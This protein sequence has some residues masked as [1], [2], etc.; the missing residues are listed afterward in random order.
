MLEQNDE[1]VAGRRVESLSS[2]SRHVWLRVAA[3]PVVHAGENDGRSD[4]GRV[5]AKNPEAGELMKSERRFSLQ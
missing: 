1:R 3:R 4:A 2:S 5:L